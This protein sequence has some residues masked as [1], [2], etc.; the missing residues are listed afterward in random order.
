MRNTVAVTTARLTISSEEATT[1][2][3]K[4]C[5]NNSMVVDF[6]VLDVH[7]LVTLSRELTVALSAFLS[8]QENT[9]HAV[10]VGTDLRHVSVL[11]DLQQVVSI[12]AILFLHI[13][14]ANGYDHFGEPRV[15]NGDE[16]NF[17]TVKD[18]FVKR[19]AIP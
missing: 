11:A 13:K 8:H 6:I 19:E 1:V 10:L 5:S 16:V 18:H 14:T 4:D 7:R 17:A 9:I 2:F 12:S 3:G 15:M